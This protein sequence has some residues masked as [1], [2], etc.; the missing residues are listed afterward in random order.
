VKNRGR[1]LGELQYIL[2]TSD[3][4]CALSNL[5]FLV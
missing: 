1:E 2:F 3:F 5:F 4:M